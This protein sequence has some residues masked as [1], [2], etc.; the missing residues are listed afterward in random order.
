MPTSPVHTPPVRDRRG[1]QAENVFLSEA[2]TG[3]RGVPEEVI[4]VPLMKR[5]HNC[6]K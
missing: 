6:D 5:K 4:G 3:K 2:L 1:K